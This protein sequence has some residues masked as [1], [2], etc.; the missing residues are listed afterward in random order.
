[1]SSRRKINKVKVFYNIYI[2]S[3]IDIII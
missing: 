3:Y 1:M 2:V